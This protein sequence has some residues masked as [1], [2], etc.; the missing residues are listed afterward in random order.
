MYLF[1]VI[2]REKTSLICCSYAMIVFLSFDLDYE[3][4]VR[5]IISRNQKETIEVKYRWNNS[6][7]HKK[8]LTIKKLD[9]R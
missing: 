8:S 6:P 2:T 3:E 5:K 4:K 9:W 7:K 1:M